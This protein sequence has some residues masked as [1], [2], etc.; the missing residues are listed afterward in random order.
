MKVI[1]F[2]T[3]KCLRKLLKDFISEIWVIIRRNGANNSS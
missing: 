1:Y 2:E 3:V